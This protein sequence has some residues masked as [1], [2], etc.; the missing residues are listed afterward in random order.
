MLGFTY[1]L[2]D[3]WDIL[4]HGGYLAG[5]TASYQVGDV[6]VTS[7]LSYVPL[8]GGVR[9]YLS[10]P[11]AIRFYG[12]AEAGAMMVSVSSSASSGA[13]SAW[14]SGSSTYFG[15]AA[16][17]GLQGDILDVRAGVLTADL[18]HAGTSTSGMLSL[19]L[20]FLNW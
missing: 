20:R 15:G 11:G 14:G 4:F 18:G 19:G 16:S 2:D 3:R 5:S 7:S 13:G 8:L 12:S 10:S 6:S 17:L 9:Y 1:E